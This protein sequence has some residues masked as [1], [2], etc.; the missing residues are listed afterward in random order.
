[1]KMREARVV[2]DH[3]DFDEVGPVQLLFQVGLIFRGLLEELKENGSRVLKAGK[4]ID[5]WAIRGCEYRCARTPASEKRNELL[6][7]VNLV[8]KD[9]KT[10]RSRQSKR[11]VG[12]A[13]SFFRSKGGQGNRTKQE[14]GQKGEKQASEGNV[15]A[16]GLYRQ[17]EHGA[18]GEEGQGGK[19]AEV[20][21]CRKRKL[22]EAAQGSHGEEKH[23]LLVA[24]CGG[25]LIAA[26]K[27]ND[28]GSRD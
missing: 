7:K 2:V 5:L 19:V 18:K 28:E 16:M 17:G 24:E 13:G 26:K 23:N 4:E 21:R 8:L 12:E 6:V 14:D 10:A 15:K 1:M 27:K 3:D 25:G 9:P 22:N 11:H 20:E